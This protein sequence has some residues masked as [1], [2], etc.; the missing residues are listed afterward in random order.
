MVILAIKVSYRQPKAPSEAQT[1]KG[2]KL[3]LTDWRHTDGGTTKTANDTAKQA[4][5]AQK[6]SEIGFPKTR[7]R[8][9]SSSTVVLSETG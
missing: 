7:N 1:E 9:S 3:D 8:I 2:G 5:E 4:G 6:R